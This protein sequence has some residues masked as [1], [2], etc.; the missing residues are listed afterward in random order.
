MKDHMT[1]LSIHDSS[2]ESKNGYNEGKKIAVWSKKGK[3]LVNAELFS[4]F[5][6]N[7]KF[8]LAECLYDNQISLNDT[9]KQIRKSFERTKQFIDTFFAEE[10]KQGQM[11]FIFYISRNFRK[12]CQFNK[13][14][15]V[16]FL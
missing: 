11:V 1:Y 14:K 9:K 10:I 12:Y 6:N 3:T 2:K 16:L 8:D 5:L 15:F 4:D 13:K 7:V